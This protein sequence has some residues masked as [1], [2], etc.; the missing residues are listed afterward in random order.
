MSKINLEM[1]PPFGNQ[2]ELKYARE[3]C[4]CASALASLTLGHAAG[5]II[6]YMEKTIG[7]HVD[8][9]GMLTMC[10]AFHDRPLQF[11]PHISPK[12]SARN[13]LILVQ[14]YMCMYI[15]LYKE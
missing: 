9:N 3:N 15:Y 14:I 1:A 12:R 8:E 6:Y 11:A 13:A 10:V 7:F 5:G 4:W 2:R